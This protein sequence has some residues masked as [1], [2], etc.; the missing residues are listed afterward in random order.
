MNRSPI[1]LDLFNGDAKN[2]GM[3]EPVSWRGSD[4]NVMRSLDQ[5]IGVRSTIHSGLMN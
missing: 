5:T 2:M 3:A 1:R 4:Q